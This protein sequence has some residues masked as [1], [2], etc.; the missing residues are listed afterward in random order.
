MELQSYIENIA[1]V[2]AEEIEDNLVGVY[3][4]GS[5]AMGCFNPKTSDVDLLVI[6]RKEI[7]NNTKKRIIKKLLTLTQG[8]R[9][10]LETSI[11][12]ERYLT[13][14]VYP[15]PFELHYFHP[16]YLTDET[17][18]CGG[19]GFYDPD[20][21]GHI[22]VTNQRGATIIGKDLKEVFKPIDMQYYVESIFNDI[23]D[24]NSGITDNPV[25][26]TLNLCRVM[27][28][29][30]EGTIS[31]KKEGGEWGISNLPSNFRSIV[32]Q[33]LN[34]YCG[35]TKK[36]HISND[37]LFQFANWMLSECKQLR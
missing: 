10:Q 13:D 25:Y 16:K 7:S 17:Y 36:V 34:V 20:L 23:Q 8:Y 9:N 2:F 31:S 35:V 30:K 24:A 5:L 26:F 6:C 27:Y 1:N 28:F 37:E 33:C 18:I 12:L 21:A 3:L 4:H 22:V 32:E 14:F 29:L 19:E 11:I 15:T